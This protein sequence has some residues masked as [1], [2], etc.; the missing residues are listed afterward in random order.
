MAIL[1]FSTQ[2]PWGDQTYF[3]PKIWRGLIDNLEMYND[4]MSYVATILNSGNDKMMETFIPVKDINTIA[5]KIH[6]IRKDSHDLWNTGRK[7][8]MVVFN[9]TKNRFQFAPVLECKSVQRIEI[10]YIN[11]GNEVIIVID[12]THFYN[13]LLNINKG[14]DMLAQNDGFI[15]PLYFL[16]YF[17]DNFSGK[18]ISWI[19]HK[20]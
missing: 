15:S 20:Y 6:T 4:Y 8:H 9:R 7:I 18:I 13:S 11:N 3:I 1:S 16:T 10:E 5:P 12:G 14:I 19:N 2:F 17:S